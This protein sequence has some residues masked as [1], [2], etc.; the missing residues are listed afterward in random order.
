[1]TAVK[2]YPGVATITVHQDDS[3]DCW[4]AVIDTHDGATYSAK[5]KT[6]L[7]AIGA[8]VGWMLEAQGG[9]AK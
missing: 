4:K 8:A 6:G 3:P 7:E 5:G 1:M 2:G 9:V